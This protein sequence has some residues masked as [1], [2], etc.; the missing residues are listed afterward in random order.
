MHN[1]KNNLVKNFPTRVYAV[2]RDLFSLFSFTYT[3]ERQQNEFKSLKLHQ[4]AMH[5]CFRFF[6]PFFTFFRESQNFMCVA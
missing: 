6:L 4:C 2:Q 3:Y 5:C 1:I